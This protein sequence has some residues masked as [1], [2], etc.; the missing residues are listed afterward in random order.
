RLMPGEESASVDVRV[1]MI[2][3]N[4]VTGNHSL[5]ESCKP[6]MEY[7]RLMDMIKEEKDNIGLKQAI[8]KAIASVTEDWRIYEAIQSAG[9]ELDDMILA[10]FDEEK[11]A[12]SLF[13]QG[14][15]EGI[16]E[17]IEKNSRQTVIRMIQNNCSDQLIQNI[18]PA[19]SL[20]EIQKLREDFRNHPE[21]YREL[22][23]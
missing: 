12:K 15:A 18:A 19:Y 4:Y 16:A 6:L 5:L 10:E 7:S 1:K 3:I 17:G 9:K 11:F 21:N 23:N 22:L 13:E 14:K 20:E 8:R 2:N